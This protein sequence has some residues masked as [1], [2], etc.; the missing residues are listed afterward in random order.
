MSRLNV[1][2]LKGIVE[3]LPDDFEIEFQERDDSISPVSDEVT[4]IVSERKLVLK[5]Y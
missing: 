1:E 4:V 3:K 2:V 5:L